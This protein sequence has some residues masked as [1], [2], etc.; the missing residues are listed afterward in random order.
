MPAL[1]EEDI[2]GAMEAALVA[3]CW[4]LPEV[5]R[6]MDTISV[7]VS[8]LRALALE[9]LTAE[10]LPHEYGPGMYR[11]PLPPETRLVGVV[12]RT[13]SYDRPDLVHKRTR[14]FRREE[15]WMAVLRSDMPPTTPGFRPGADTLVGQVVRLT[16]PGQVFTEE[17]PVLAARIEA[18]DE[19]SR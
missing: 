1:P 11:E 15:P 17:V 4:Q 7:Q 13:T 19:D 12:E 18:D 3:E 5:L 10:E 8:E 2:V 16:A 14:F 6:G 9:L